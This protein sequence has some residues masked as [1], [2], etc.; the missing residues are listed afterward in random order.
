[1][2]VVWRGDMLLETIIGEWSLL[3]KQ[4]RKEKSMEEHTTREEPLSEELLDGIT[5]AGGGASRLGNPGPGS[6]SSCPSCQAN[7][8][9]YSQHI[10]IRDGLQRNVDSHVSLGDYAGGRYKS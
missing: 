3:R 6:F 2:C 5:G 4:R 7:E 1:M 9:K 8:Q 10:Y